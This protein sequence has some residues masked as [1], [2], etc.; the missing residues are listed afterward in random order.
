[1]GE[2]EWDDPGGVPRLVPWR[3]ELARRGGK[4]PEEGE[5]DEV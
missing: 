3:V 2:F 5:M 1:M 4:L